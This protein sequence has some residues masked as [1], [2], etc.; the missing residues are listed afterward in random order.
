MSRKAA[1]LVEV[2]P[3]RADD[4]EFFTS[5]NTLWVATDSTGRRFGSSSEGEA[6]QMLEQYNSRACRARNVSGAAQ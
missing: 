6:R 4:G 5:S 1:H 2:R 3:T